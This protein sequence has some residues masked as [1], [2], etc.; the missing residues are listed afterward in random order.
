MSEIDISKM[1]KPEVLAALYNASKPQG[2]GITLHPK[3]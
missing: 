2:I 1:N 3:K